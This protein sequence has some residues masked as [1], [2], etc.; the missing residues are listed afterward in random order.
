MRQTM[1]AAN[2]ADPSRA[3]TAA[4]GYNGD[5]PEGLRR[6]VL[7]GTTP[8]NSD[9]PWEGASKADSCTVWPV[10]SNPGIS[11]RTDRARAADAVLVRRDGDAMQREISRASTWSL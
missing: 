2:H 9:M 4:K 8:I 1:S 5:P 10:L 7:L 3:I 11:R 6:C